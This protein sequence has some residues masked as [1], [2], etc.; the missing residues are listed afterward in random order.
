MTALLLLQIVSA[1]YSMPWQLRP[2]ALTTSV[3]VDSLVALYDTPAGS[4][5][6]VPVLVSASFRLTS[7]LGALVRIGAVDSEPPTGPAASVFANPIIGATYLVPLGDALRLCGFF[8]LA[9]PLGMGGGDAPD[10][11][12]LAAEKSAMTARSAMDNAMFAVNDFTIFPGVGLAW[13]KGGWTVQGEVTLLQ[14]FRVRGEMAQK[15]S[16]KTNF[17]SGV[18]VGYF[19][20]PWLSVGA[21]VRYQRWLSTP[22]AV[23][24]DMTGTLRDTL[25][26]AIGP[27]FHHRLGEGWI[28]PGIAYARGLR[29]T[30]DAQSYNIIQFDLPVS[31]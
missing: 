7:R 30:L 26:V 16:A 24:A 9:L 15:D 18:H 5:E 12:A 10:A 1:P 13:V 8:G 22:A 11:A 23:E 4:G 19:A 2:T 28:R 25:S 3:R 20:I 6:T 31:F 17:T 27:R 14:L 21:E 29:G